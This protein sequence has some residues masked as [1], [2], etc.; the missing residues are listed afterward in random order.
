MARSHG[1]FLLTNSET[2]SI[3]Y[4]LNMSDLRR[5]FGLQLKMLRR[6]REMTQEELAQA[7]GLSTSFI[8]SIE[9]GVNAPSF[10]SLEALSYALGIKPSDLF[11]FSNE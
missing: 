4:V 1:L 5:K 2:V 8:R 9:Q 11:E 6:D 7:A 3:G 10:N